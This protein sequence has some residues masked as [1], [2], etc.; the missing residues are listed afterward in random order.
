MNVAARAHAY[1]HDEPSTITLLKR[2]ASGLARIDYAGEG[3]LPDQYG[4]YR[5]RVTA[6]IMDM[7]LKAF[8]L[9]LLAGARSELCVSGRNPGLSK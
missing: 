7:T 6:Q 1:D 8:E 9:P 3:L 5:S 4:G 2:A